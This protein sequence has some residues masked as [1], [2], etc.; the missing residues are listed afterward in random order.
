MLMKSIMYS[1]FRVES[2]STTPAN[3]A[4]SPKSPIMEDVTFSRASPLM[5]HLMTTIMMENM[6]R[7]L[8]LAD[9]Y[10][11]YLSKTSELLTDQI[12]L[13]RCYVISIFRVS[14]Y[15]LKSVCSLLFYDRSAIKLK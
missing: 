1:S 9:T 14:E 6:D 10:I 2:S 3:E 7:F 5:L 8:F 12:I 11:D 4:S 15:L 13:V